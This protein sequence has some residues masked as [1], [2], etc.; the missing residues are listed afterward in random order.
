MQSLNTEVRTFTAYDGGLLQDDQQRQKML[1]NFM[2]PYSLT[3]KVGAQVMLIKNLD[4]TLV[5]GSM[6][7]VIKFADPADPTALDDVGAPVGTR[8]RPA[9]L[10]KPPSKT[11]KEAQLAGTGQL[12]PVVDFL[13]P[14]GGMRRHLVMADVFKVELPSGEV[15]VSRTQVC[16]LGL[17]SARVRADEVCWFVAAVDPCVGDVD[18]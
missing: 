15:Q 5:N 1:N 9:P 4:E 8:S 16:V 3:L 6:G 11:G 2:V 17:V 18:T 13:V 14:G 12:M 7:K 10:A